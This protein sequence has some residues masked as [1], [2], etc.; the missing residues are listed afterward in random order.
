MQDKFTHNNLLPESVFLA[1]GRLM[2]L[3]RS[4]DHV[5]SYNITLLD[6]CIKFVHIRVKSSLSEMSALNSS[7][8]GLNLHACCTGQVYRDHLAKIC[9]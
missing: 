5:A 2:W 9:I 4:H 6:R 8:Q 1:G 3:S 7:K